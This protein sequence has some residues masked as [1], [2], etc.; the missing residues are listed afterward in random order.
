[1]RSAPELNI[2]TMQEGK[3]RCDK[4]KIMSETTIAAISTAYGEAGIGIVR[5]SG[6]D[7]LNVLRKVFVPGRAGQLQ[8]GAAAYDSAALVPGSAQSWSPHPRHMYFGRIVDPKDGRVV[9]ECLAVFMPGPQSYTGEDVAEV[10]CHGSVLSYKKI[11]ALMLQNGA[12][13]AEPGEFTKRAFLNGRMDLAQAEAVIDL[14][15]ARSARSFDCAVG[16][17]EGS[18]SQKIRAV[19]AELLDLLTE[20]A[21]NMDYPDEDIEELTYGRLGNRISLI[22]DELIKLKESS[23]EGR[24]LREGLLAAI[25]GK[26]NVGKSS[27]MNVLLREDRS[28]VT[29]VPGTTRDTIE[30]QISMRGITIRFVDT[31]G[32]RSSADKVESIGIERSKDAFNRAELLLLVLDSSER[33]SAEDLEL[34]EMA[35]DRPVI[36]ILNKDD[37]PPAGPVEPDTG[38]A[39]CAGSSVEPASSEKGLAWGSPENEVRRILPGARVVKL[40]AKTCDGIVQ[41]EDSIEEFVTGGRVRREEDVLVTNVRHIA[42]IDKA[43]EELSQAARMTKASEAMDFIEV[44]VRAAF[45]ALGE[46]T[47]E[48]ASGEVIEEVFRRFCLGK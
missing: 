32:I 37:L 47:G 14:I 43:I 9:D 41:L 3:G 44:N 42:L 36:V 17:L 23:A 22:N 38:P 4:R 12:Q 1:M 24:I 25:V 11:L 10:Q 8:N 26:P 27:L 19:R 5:M 39:A 15:K 45:D 34:M 33:I 7:S 18:L 21:V 13:P 46:I 35:K 29:D 2:K 20:L 31:A 30:E 28:I 16:Q 40:S 48:T 6:P